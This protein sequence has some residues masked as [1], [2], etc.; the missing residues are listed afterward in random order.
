[1]A[2]SCAYSG[3]SIFSI[4]F[5][6][7]LSE[8]THFFVEL[9][10]SIC[11]LGIIALLCVVVIRLRHTLDCF[12]IIRSFRTNG[13]IFRGGHLF[14]IKNKFVFLVLL[15]CL[16]KPVIEC[17]QLVFGVAAFFPEIVCSLAAITA[18]A[19]FCEVLLLIFISVH[20]R[21]IYLRVHLIRALAIGCTCTCSC[22]CRRLCE[23]VWPGCTG[24]RLNH[25][26][27]RKLSHT[28]RTRR[29]F[30]ST[31]AA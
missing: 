30:A 9:S 19:Y 25:M 18:L 11:A 23:A 2:W 21:N 14:P 1:M 12:E 28:A 24:D 17:L 6:H 22:L 27:C 31:T 7:Y 3:V 13:M 20:S 10:L 5:S 15:L 4:D 8:V 16:S 26:L 29:F